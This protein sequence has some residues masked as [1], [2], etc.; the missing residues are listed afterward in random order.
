MQGGVG[1]IMDANGQIGTVVSSQR[2]KDE[3]E[4]MGKT[5]ES[6]LKLEPVTFR[7]KRA[8]RENPLC[9]GL[10][11]EQ[12]ERGSILRWLCTTSKASLS[13]CAKKR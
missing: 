10:V 4:P 1:V 8:C 13:M 11:A 5:S 12:V 6:I 3:I 2:F 7:Y 9:F